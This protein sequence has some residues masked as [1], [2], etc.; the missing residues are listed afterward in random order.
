MTKDLQ[1]KAIDIKGKKYV[2]VSDRI[3]YFNEEYPSGCIKTELISYEDKQIVVKALVYPDNTAPMSRYFTGYAQEIEGEGYINKT[4]ALENAE[5]SA[6]G[7]ALAMMGI[8]VIDSIAS[9]DEI[10]KANNRPKVNHMPAKN[11]VPPDSQNPHIINNLMTC[12]SIA[13]LGLLWESI[14]TE[15]KPKYKTI[16]DN[17]KEQLMK[18]K[19]KEQESLT[20]NQ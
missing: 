10:N 2:Q 13:E 15:D 11:I 4:S 16:K 12:P 6:V 5:T 20:K 9:I 8:G 1:E 3:L 14:S 19:I 18:D 17:R 7:R